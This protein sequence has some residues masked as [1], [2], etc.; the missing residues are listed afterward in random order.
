MISKTH[1][2]YQQDEATH[3]I[4]TSKNWLA[5]GYSRVGT[6]FRLKMAPL[7]FW[8]KLTQ[9]DYLQT[10]K[11][12]N[13][14]QILNIQINLDFKF[15]LP[16]TIMI[17]RSNFLRKTIPSVE[18]TKNQHQYWIVHIQISLSTNFQIKLTIAMFWTKFAKKGS[19]FQSKTD[20]IDTTI[21]FCIFELLL[22]SFYLKIV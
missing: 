4:K 1:Q 8:I 11:S 5:G 9:K 22:V 12:E 17:F 3:S 21:E 20:K 16:Q 19:Y 13:Y 6:K 15:Q 18:N 14:H 10:K 7:N 2:V